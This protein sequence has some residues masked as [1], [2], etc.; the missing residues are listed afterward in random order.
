M[1]FKKG[2]KAWNKGLTRKTS[3][4]IDEMSKKNRNWKNPREVIKKMAKSQKERLK[5]KTKHP[6][7][8]RDRKGP[9]NGNW[10]G[11][12]TSVNK[13]IRDSQKYKL[14]RLMVFGRD[15]YTCQECGKRGVYL[16]AHHIKNFA[17]YPDLRFDISNGK[18]L[19]KKCHAK[20]PKGREINKM[21]V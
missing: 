2:Q 7:Y 20:K 14:W 11:G 3:K 18:T 10:K 1:V 9:K 12:I 5:D 21:E 15:N 6:M 4:L 13:K 17:Q 19:C 16:H 8:G